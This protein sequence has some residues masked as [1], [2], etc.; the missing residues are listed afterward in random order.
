[1]MSWLITHILHM[2]KTI[3]SEQHAVD[4]STLSCNFISHDMTN[5]PISWNAPL[6]C[7]LCGSCALQLLNIKI[8]YYFSKT[9]HCQKKDWHTFSCKFRFL[10]CQLHATQKRKCTSIS[11]K[12]DS[13]TRCVFSVLTKLKRKMITIIKWRMKEMIGHANCRA[14]NGVI[15]SSLQFFLH[16]KKVSILVTDYGITF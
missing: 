5:R 3:L 15:S 14:I 7:H 16:Q 11:T 4:Q 6:L 1:M 2:F 12:K 8:S 10:M 13:Q 9:S